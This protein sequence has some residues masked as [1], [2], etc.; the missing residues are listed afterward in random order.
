MLADFLGAIK[1]GGVPPIPLA[2]I[3]AVTRATFAVLESLRCRAVVFVEPRM[4]TN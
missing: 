4:D 1:D 3:F 2:E